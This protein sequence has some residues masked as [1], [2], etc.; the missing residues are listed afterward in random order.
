MRPQVVASA[1]LE[2]VPAERSQRRLQLLALHTPTVPISG[3]DVKE[4][5]VSAS[6]SRG[7]DRIGTDRAGVSFDAAFEYDHHVGF[8]SG[9]IAYSDRSAT[10]R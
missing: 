3:Y 4:C 10:L 8:Q 6:A 7:R 9:A 1:V 2:E 5:L